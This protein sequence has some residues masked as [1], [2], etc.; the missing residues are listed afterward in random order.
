MHVISN[1][2]GSLIVE[3]RLKICPAIQ[4]IKLP[5]LKGQLQPYFRAAARSRQRAEHHCGRDIGDINNPQSWPA[6]FLEGMW[7]AL[8]TLTYATCTVS[9]ATMTLSL[10]FAKSATTLAAAVA[11]TEKP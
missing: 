2:L 10:V 5:P 9:A 8:H 3:D 6:N 7:P 4:V 1:Y 11:S